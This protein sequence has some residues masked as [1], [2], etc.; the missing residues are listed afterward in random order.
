M[1]CEEKHTYAAWAHW[2]SRH[3]SRVEIQRNETH[4]QT[5]TDRDAKLIFDLCNKWS[6]K[7]FLLLFIFLLRMLH[8]HN[9]VHI[10]IHIRTVGESR[11]PKS[12]QT[13]KPA[14]I[15]RRV[16]M[17][18]K[19]KPGKNNNTREGSQ[20]QNQNHLPIET[21][22][23]W[24]QVKYTFFGGRSSVTSLKSSTEGSPLPPNSSPCRKMCWNV[25]MELVEGM[26][27]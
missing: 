17:K 11:I 8:I 3:K 23:H 10:H 4:H 13:P 21:A 14:Y 20:K 7:L 1:S 26:G 18:S 16:V 12:K 6:E 25:P 19:Q 22:K 27:H 2:N 15:N 24:S 9:Q 5:R